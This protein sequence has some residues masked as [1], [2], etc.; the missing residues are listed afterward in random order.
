MNFDHF[1]HI[2]YVVFSFSNGKTVV[3]FLGCWSKKTKQSEDSTLVS[4]LQLAFF[5]IFLHFIAEDWQRKYNMR[6]NWWW[7]NH[8]LQTEYVIKP[9]LWV[10]LRPYTAVSVFSGTRGRCSVSLARSG[11]MWQVISGTLWLDKQPSEARCGLGQLHSS[12]H[13]GQECP[14]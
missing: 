4:K 3:F 7:N 12:L 8:Y 11:Y 1:K 14:I 9:F 10:R 13:W 6:V 2:S 5:T